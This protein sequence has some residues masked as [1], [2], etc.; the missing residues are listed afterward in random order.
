MKF[1]ELENGN[2]INPDFIE[3][4]YKLNQLDTHW[5]AGTNHGE[6]VDITDTDRVRII[7]AVGLV[8]INKNEN[9]EQGD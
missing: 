8:N 3:E 6:A 4:I 1:I 2:W 7:K 5:Q 9:D